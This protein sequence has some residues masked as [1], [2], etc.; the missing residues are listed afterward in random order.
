M[1][2][3]TQK[4]IRTEEHHRRPVSL[5]GSENDPSNVAFVLPVPHRSWHVLFGNMNAEQICNRIN[6][7]PWKPEGITIIC[8]FINGQEI[9]ARG[10][11]NSKNEKKCQEAWNLL[12]RNI[13]FQEIV[14]YINSVWL[15][16]SYHFY[17]KKWN[18]PVDDRNSHRQVGF[19]YFIYMH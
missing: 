4:I 15:D 10:G 14:N 13:S 12:F 2:K 5:G 18:P 1:K 8:K 7:S 19:S 6:S 16:P 3:K 9:K 17:T 11:K